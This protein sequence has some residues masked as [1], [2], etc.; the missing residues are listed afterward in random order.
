LDPTKTGKELMQ[1][2]L[3]QIISSLCLI[4]ELVRHSVLQCNIDVGRKERTIDVFHIGGSVM[5]KW[6]VKMVMMKVISALKEN[7]SKDNFNARMET[8]H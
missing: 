6:T 2:V 4:N 7:A 3:A 5:V 8:V 1:R